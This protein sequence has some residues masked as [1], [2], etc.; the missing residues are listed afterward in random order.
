MHYRV[1]DD[2][3]FSGLTLLVNQS[4]E[5]GWRPQG[6]VVVAVMQGTEGPTVRYFQAVVKQGDDDPGAAATEGRASE[7]PDAG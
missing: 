4:T 3:R 5:H 6:R 7:P 1:I 2:P